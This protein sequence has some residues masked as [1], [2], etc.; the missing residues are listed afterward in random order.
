MKPQFII[1]SGPN[2]AGK[3]VLGHRH[4]PEGT[5]IFNGD[6]VFAELIRQYPH[7][8]PDRLSG[9]VALAL[10]KARDKAIA[11]KTN[12]AFESNFS[13]DMAI[14]ISNTFSHAGY[15][16]SLVY[17]GLNSLENSVLRVDTRATLGGHGVS[18][19]VIRFN[20]QEGI[21][22]TIKHL[23]I[24]DK[25]FFTDAAVK[26]VTPIIAYFIKETGA[27]EILAENIKWFNEN[28]RIPLYEYA[29]TRLE[30]KPQGNSD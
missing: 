4:V 13:N 12:F 6:L 2:G 25:I 22:R 3:S 28:F 21:K 26:D 10:E 16:T 27:C 24:F 9:G 7:I 8:E 17:F 15:E 5:P 23:N 30:Q 20:M 14:D 29:L 18:P 1:I 11:N 19:E